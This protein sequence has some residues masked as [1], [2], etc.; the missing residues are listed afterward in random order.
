MEDASEGTLPTEWMDAKCM[1]R[2]VRGQRLV[3][4]VHSA[5][6]IVNGYSR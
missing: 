5:T 2:Q 4:C 3:A 1:A 6:V